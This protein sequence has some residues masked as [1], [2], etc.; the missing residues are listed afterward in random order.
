MQRLMFEAPG[1]YA[2]RQASEPEVTAPE[3]AIVRPLAVAC[4]ALD[5]A[6]AEGRLPMPA[7]HAVGHEGV[8]EVMAVG[9]AVRD[10]TVGDRVVVPFQVHCGSC[11]AC[12]RRVT[13]YCH[14]VALM[15]MYG[16]AT[17]S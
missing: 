17:L 12:R 7:G 13:G 10:V 6:V 14:S 15:P 16:I 3:Q 9:D 4:C 5:V 11:R 1:E 2:W 8:A